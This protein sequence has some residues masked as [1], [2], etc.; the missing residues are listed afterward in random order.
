M[1]FAVA[2]VVVI[3]L[4]VLNVLIGY[5]TLNDLL[6]NENDGEVH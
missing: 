4:G 1:D 3:I 2:L 6:V 5:E